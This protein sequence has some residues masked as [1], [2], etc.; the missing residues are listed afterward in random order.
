[1]SQL[2]IMTYENIH[3]LFEL[4]IFGTAY[5]NQLIQQT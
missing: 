1:M 3:L 2:E 4:Y 5:L